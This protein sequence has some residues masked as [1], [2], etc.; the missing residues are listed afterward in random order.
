LTKVRFSEEE[1]AI[2][3]GKEYLSRKKRQ[4]DEDLGQALTSYR[5]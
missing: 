2:I 1:N 5:L 3:F 4:V